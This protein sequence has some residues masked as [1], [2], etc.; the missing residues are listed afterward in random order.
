M[1][2]EK[3]PKAFSRLDPFVHHGSLKALFLPHF[4]LGKS[5]FPLLLGLLHTLTLI[6]GISVFISIISIVLFQACASL[7]SLC[8]GRANRSSL[9]MHPS[10]PSSFPS[11]SSPWQLGKSLPLRVR[12]WT[13]EPR[14]SLEGAPDR[15]SQSHYG[16]ER[17]PRSSIQ[18]F[19]KYPHIHSST[20]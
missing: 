8:S 7:Y 4:P 12:S 11:L 18:P 14:A 19:T 2:L 20:Q 16:W 5:C 13:E 9:G 15:E 1:S 6:P 17:I 3:I 10:A